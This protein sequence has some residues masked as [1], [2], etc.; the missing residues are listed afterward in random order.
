MDNKK[1]QEIL[2]KITDRIVEVP[3]N[4]WKWTGTS[5]VTWIG[6]HKFTLPADFDHSPRIGAGVS[7]EVCPDMPGNTRNVSAVRALVHELHMIQD[8]VIHD[9]LEDILADLEKEGK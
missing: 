8:D 1:K 5:W 6:S 7:N 2:N 9:R 3:L 4:E